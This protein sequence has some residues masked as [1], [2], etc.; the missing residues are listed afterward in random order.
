TIPPLMSAFIIHL[1][2]GTRPTIYG[3]GSKRRDFVYV[4]DVN[5]FHMQCLTDDRTV[6]GAFN[7]GSGDSHSVRE[8]LD[9]T[10]AILGTRV[11]PIFRPDLPGEAK[12][13]QADTTLARS[14]GWK[15]K[16]SLDEGLE[17][18]IAYIRDHVLP[19]LPA[20]TAA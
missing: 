6:G 7:L 8:I 18:S 14:L 4:D 3:D 20:T 5:D 12:E 2:R 16:V 13:T 9:R 19:V 11:E 17:R 10:S 15:P 1:L